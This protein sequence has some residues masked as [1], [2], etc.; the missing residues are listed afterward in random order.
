MKFVEKSSADPGNRAVL[1][2]AQEKGAIL[3]QWGSFVSFIAIGMEPR[4]L[5]VLSKL[6]ATELYW[7]KTAEEGR[8]SHED[9]AR[10]KDDWSD[11]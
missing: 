4:T 6:S 8:R 11:C 2:Q 3:P 5:H 7:H 1:M 10:D 9:K